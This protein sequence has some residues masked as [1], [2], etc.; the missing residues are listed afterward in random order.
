ML[1]RTCQAADAAPFTDIHT[2]TPAITPAIRAQASSVVT[3]L[4]RLAVAAAPAL[5]NVD[6]AAR[7][8]ALKLAI[9]AL[10]EAVPAIAQHMG[11][12][13]GWAN[14]ESTC[15]ELC[16]T[17]QNVGGSGWDILRELLRLLQA[18]PPPVRVRVGLAA[19]A[20]IDA[21]VAVTVVLA[22][23]SAAGAPAEVV[24]AV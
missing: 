21:G 18:V 6:T 20:E 7:L 1:L 11:A 16:A 9:A 12:R 2:I 24:G 10:R 22:L 4:I 5:P 13:A 19:A 17:W 3:A 15:R 8:V 14:V 23:R